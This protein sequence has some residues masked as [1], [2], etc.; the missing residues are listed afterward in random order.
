[1]QDILR[2]LSSARARRRARRAL[3]AGAVYRHPLETPAGKLRAWGT[4][5]IDGSTLILNDVSVYPE[6]PG[7][8]ARF[9]FGLRELVRLRDEVAS[10]AA[11]AG[12][13]QLRIRALRTDRLD[14]RGAHP[15]VDVNVDLAPYRRT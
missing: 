6:Q 11:L 4:V 2:T 1:V 15:L 3:R 7:Q 9:E 13:E 10:L 12:Y 14:D 5:E 8:T